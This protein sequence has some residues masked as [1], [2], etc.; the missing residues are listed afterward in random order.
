MI[1]LRFPST[2]A[3]RLSTSTFESQKRK[4]ECQIVWHQRAA[5]HDLPWETRIDAAPLHAVVLLAFVSD[6]AQP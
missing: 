5:V 3:A 4:I 6:D 1:R 2:A